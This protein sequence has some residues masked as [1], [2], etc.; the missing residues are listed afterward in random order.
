MSLVLQGSPLIKAETAARVREAAPTRSATF[1]TAAPPTLRRQSSNIIGMVINDLT[2]PF[3]AELLVGMER[4]LV[5]AGY[6]SLMAHTGRALPTQE[7]VLASMREYHA[8]GLILCPAFDTPP[9][10]A[11]D[12]SEP[13]ASRCWSWS[14]RSATAIYDFAGSDNE[15]GTFMATEH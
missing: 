10:G 9:V 7:K 8:A 3:F 14:V 4:K 1:T 5:E 15:A 2:N 13:R 12:R 11:G 6:V